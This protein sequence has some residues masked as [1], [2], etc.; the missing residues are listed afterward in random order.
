MRARVVAAGAL[1]AAL[2]WLAP[3]SAHADPERVKFLADKL[4]NDGDFRVRTNAALALGASN[5]DSAVDPLC[6]GL[7][8]GSEVVRQAAA[9]ALKRL[10]RSSAVGCLKARAAIESNEAVKIAIERAVESVQGGGGGGS[11]DPLKENPNA[12]Y[13]IALSA[14]S[15]ATGRP[16]A[17][18]ERLVLVPLRKK[19]QEASNVQLAPASETAEVARGV[20][21]KRKLKGFYLSIAIDRFDYND[22]N[23]R[24]RVKVAVFN[25]PNKSL[26]GNADASRIAP[27]VSKP[28]KQIEDQLMEVTGAAAGDQFAQNA[29][30]FVN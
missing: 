8:D 13:Y 10:G 6:G 20:L 2:A 16:Q 15:N 9:V 29:S 26:L 24:V 12:K 28:D 7:G 23:L 5:E 21:T 19:L 25:Y 3:A 4:K 11:E 27:G 14:L 17:E 18:V 1:C 22:G 30:Q